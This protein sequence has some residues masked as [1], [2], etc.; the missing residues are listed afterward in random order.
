[1]YDSATFAAST[2][3]Q[4]ITS[5]EAAQ[6]LGLKNAQTLAVWR[7]TKRYPELEYIKIGRVVRYRKEV[8]EAFL[9]SHT[10]NTNKELS[11]ESQFHPTIGTQALNF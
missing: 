9:K 7:C 8:I 3:R 11:D 10:I 1:M 6:L 4:L 5:D 2:K